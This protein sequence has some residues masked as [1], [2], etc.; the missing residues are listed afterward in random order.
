VRATLR[1]ARTVAVDVSPAYAEFAARR[2]AGGAVVLCGDVLD[3]PAIVVDT[4]VIFGRFLLSHLSN[5][6]RAVELWLER[7]SPR[8]VL[9]LE[10]VESITT[11]EPTF[12]AYR[13]HPIPPRASDAQDC[14]STDAAGHGF[15]NLGI[16]GESA[17]LVGDDITGLEASSCGVG[18]GALPACPEGTE[19]I[20]FYGLLGPDAVSITYRKPGSGLATQRTVGD[21]GAYLLVFLYNAA[22]CTEYD[23]AP[24]R[25]VSCDAELAGG[26]SPRR[27]G[28]RDKGHICP[29]S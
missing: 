6:L 12:R 18:G 16:L 10:E 2:L 13:F 9:L 26:A 27:A 1:P 5:P 21:A 23:Q 28:S 7:L 25:S 11:A 8:G 24:G 22:T 14:G 29:R 19:R 20:I 17:N 4:D 15:V 3:L